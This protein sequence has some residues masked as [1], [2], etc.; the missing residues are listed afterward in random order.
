MSNR[1]RLQEFERTFRRVFLLFFCVLSVPAFSQIK[2]NN[3]SSFASDL[4]L[5]EVNPAHAFGVLTFNTPFYIGNFKTK[6]S[7]FSVGYSFGNTWHPQSTVYYPQNLTPEQELSINSIYITDRPQFFEQQGIETRRK[8][9][10]TDGVLQNLSFTYLLQ[11]EKKGSFLF[12][13]NTYLLSGGSSPIHSF[14][15]DKFIEKFHSRFGVED[16]FN[17]KLFDFDRAQISY[18]DE[19]GREINIEKGQAFAGTFD[20]NYYRSIYRLEKRNTLLALQGGAHFILPLNI[21]YPEVAGGLSMS[22]LFRQKMS[23]KLYTELAGEFSASHYS[24]FSLGKS[25]N[26]IDRDIRLS[27]KFL[28]SVNFLSKRD[29][30]FTIGLLNNYQD[31]FLKGYIFCDTQDKYHDLGVAYLKAGDY[32]AGKTITQSVRL[33]KLTAASMYFFSIKSYLVIGWKAR[34]YDFMFTAGE[35]FWVVNNAPDIQY[36]FQFSRRLNW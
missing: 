24:L 6:S 21:Y 4:F 33:S 30:V 25:I 34:K 15:S 32:W 11:L 12:K 23:P 2:T 31:A 9:F 27:G 16:N 20:L 18:E 17:R 36:G 14:A 13:L 8:T 5:T 22:S 19:N 29:R 35:D 1:N 10:S 26:M 28:I 7:Q 3:D